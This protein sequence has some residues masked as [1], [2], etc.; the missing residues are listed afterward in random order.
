MFG[1]SDTTK[2]DICA[3]LAKHANIEEA[4][5]FGSRAKGTY[6]EGSDIDLAIKG[7]N[8][9]FSQLM[10]IGVQIEDLDILY[11]VDLVDYSKNEGTPLKEHV[12]RVGK[13]FYK[14]PLINNSL[15]DP[16]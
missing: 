14:R 4:I 3:V 10:D 16:Y 9:S 2:Q 8:I 11:K 7:D 12:D 1:L 15:P 13:L 5:I 6:R